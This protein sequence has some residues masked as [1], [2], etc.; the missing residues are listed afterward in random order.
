MV[1]PSGEVGV[2]VRVMARDSDRGQ[3]SSTSRVRALAMGH[4][5]FSSLSV[6][7]GY[8]LCLANIYQVR[9]QNASLG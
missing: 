5:C 8:A 1:R 6:G 3:G 7:P 9:G 2:G 4:A